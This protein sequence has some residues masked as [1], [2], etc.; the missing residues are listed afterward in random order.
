MKTKVILTVILV[1]SLFLRTFRA[2]DFLGFWF[3]QGRDAKLIWDFLYGTHKPFLIG[4]TTGIEGIFLGPFYYYLISPFYWLGQ[5]DPVYPALALAVITTASVY[6]I[7]RIG[8]AYF[9][10]RV[11]LLAAF[12][13]GFSAQFVSY[14][15]WL[16]NPTTL[17]FFAL[18]AFWALLKVIHSTASRITW[19]VFGLSLGLS[20]Q[21][22][23]ASAVFFLPAT[24]LIL[25]FYRQSWALNRRHLLTGLTAFGATLLPQI[26]FNIRHEN[27]LLKAFHNFLV[28]EPSFRPALTDLLTERLRFYLEIFTNKF[29]FT[30]PA[31]ILFVASFV[32]LLVLVWR[33]LPGKVL[34]AGLVWW[35]TPVLFLLFYHGNRG[36]VWDYYFSGVYPVLVLIVCAVWLAAYRRFRLIRPLVLILLTVFIFQNT[37]HHLA[38]LASQGSGYISLTHIIKAVDWVYRDA[39]GQ[40]FNTDVYVPPVISHAY[41]YVFLW[42][43]AAVH[44]AQPQSRLVTRLYTLLEPDLDHPQ[45]RAAWLTRQSTIGSLEE[46]RQLGP[47][48]VERRRRFSTNP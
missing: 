34:G 38:V 42:R 12:L 44:H 32:L 41:D 33:R 6:L 24:A 14:N 37:R 7:Y 22:E 3:D 29:Y 46:E 17:P 43:G 2:A 8:S 18:L 20:L 23:A 16:S 36:Y 39:A 9:D 48:T 27:I 5:G 4:P 31:K 30:D 21:L 1:L 28:A 11:G 35:L 19:L 45:F 15:R 40:P 25:F 13:Y 26:A 10:P 47:I